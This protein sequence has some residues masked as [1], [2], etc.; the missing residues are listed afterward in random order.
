ME[1]NRRLSTA[2]Q[3]ISAKIATEALCKNSTS[4]VFIRLC[5]NKA[6]PSCFLLLYLLLVSP[7][8]MLFVEDLGSEAKLR[9]DIF[10]RL[11]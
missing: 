4:V 6:A 3:Q 11:Q 5:Q 2:V 8:H 1:E 7:L 9:Y 10:L